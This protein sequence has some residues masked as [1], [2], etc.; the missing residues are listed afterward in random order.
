MCCFM[1][2][3]R[4]G[5]SFF[6]KFSVFLFEFSVVSFLNFLCDLSSVFHKPLHP[7]PSPLVR[8]GMEWHGL[9]WPGLA[10]HGEAMAGRGVAW[11]GR[12]GQGRAGQ[13][14]A[15]QGKAG[16]G[17][18]GTHT[19]CMCTGDGTTTEENVMIPIAVPLVP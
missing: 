10:W 17:M 5:K 6:C 16:Q 2:A 3:V 15:G 18:S 9:A 11:Q 7:L 13:G 14:R 8:H 19:C 4:K 1:Y 12:A